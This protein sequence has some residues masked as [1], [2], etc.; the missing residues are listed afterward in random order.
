MNERE[1]FVALT[2]IIRDVKVGKESK[3]WNFCNIYECEIGSNTQIGSY[4][5]IKAGAVIGDNC[6]FQSYIFIPEGTKI[7]NNVFLGPRVTFLNDMHPTA[8]KAIDKK[9]DLE[10]CVIEDDVSIGGCVTIIPGVR[11]GRGARIGSGAVVIKDVPENAVMVGNPA[12]QIGLT[13]DAR[14]KDWI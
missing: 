8:K 12:R 6:R 5:E 10:A 7:G 13:T 3:I 9:W 14:Y 4:S 2:A 11:V 1:Y